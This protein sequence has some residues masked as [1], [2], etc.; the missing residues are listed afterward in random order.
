MNIAIL[1]SGHGR[2]TNAEAIMQAAAK[3]DCP[4][5]VCAVV[6]AAP[7]HGALERATRYGVPAIVV[8]A[9][10][11]VDRSEFESRVLAVLDEHTTEAIA[12]AG[13]MRKLSGDF[14]SRYSNRILNVHPGLLPSFGGRGMYGR[15]VHEAV[16]AYG[17]KVSGCTV[18]FADD[19]YDHG[20]IVLQ[21]TVAVLDDDAP[22]TLAARILPNE[23]KAYVEA[24]TLLAS[25]RLAVIGRRVRQVPPGVFVVM[26][27]WGRPVAPD[28]AGLLQCAFAIRKEVFCVE[29]HVPEDLELDEY[30][31]AAWH[32]LAFM[33]GVPVATARLLNKGGAA[34]IGRVA[35]LKAYRGRGLGVKVMEWAMHMAK[36]LKLQPMILDAQVPVIPFYERLGF[37]AEGPVFDDAGIPHRRMTKP[38]GS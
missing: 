37:V 3:A 17:A 34:K 8:D 22:E 6:S 21:K 4:F 29:Q 13:F 26:G 9:A 19:Q 12:L 16:L 20:P 2:G 31:A 24:L 5:R 7:G 36:D 23:H 11:C 32:F 14:T 1:V 10:G 35:V 30:D 33:D 38:T 15:H 18:H 25:G 28:D 27:E